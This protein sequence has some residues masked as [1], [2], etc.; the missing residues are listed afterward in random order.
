MR[1][2]LLLS[3]EFISASRR[4]MTHAFFAAVLVT[5]LSAVAA[6]A[7]GEQEAPGNV[8]LA[9]AEV[10]T[11]GAI[12]GDL[13]AA[14]GRITVDHPVAGDAV[15]GGGAIE[16]H[17][18]IG[19][20]LRAAGG[21][22][23][24]SGFVAGEALLAGGSVALGP[25]SEVNGRAWLVGNDVVAG[26]RVRG[27]LKVYG[28]HILVLG[29]INGPVDLSGDSI[30]IT[31]AARI[32]GNV[33]YSSKHEIE[34]D[35]GARV[36]GKITREAS[37]FEFYHPKLKIP[38][39]PAFRPL[40]LLGLL[41]AGTLL[42]LLFPRFTQAALAAVGSSPLKS[43]GLGT[44]VFFSLPPVILL[45]IITIIGI[46]IALALAALYA[47]ALLVGYLII[48]FFLGDRLLGALRKEAVARLGWRIG[49]LALALLLLWLVR[50][51]PYVGGF[52]ILIALLAGIGAI[53]L[54]AFSHYSDRP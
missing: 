26:G 25:E 53:V 15:L 27:G 1:W 30:E 50:H 51:V 31:R 12:S 41:A 4:S 23:N 3:T 19:D 8:Y 40:F 44:A 39:W 5:G 45:L 14:A 24:V 21:I 18:R 46:P 52:A 11:G 32:N 35:P 43:L 28:K 29:E 16:V 6:A 20:D 13:V 47:T 10:R 54:Q 9:G 7:E 17:G 34:V 2:P 22:I 37:T 42:V 33:T 48:A 49:S 38:G 36:S